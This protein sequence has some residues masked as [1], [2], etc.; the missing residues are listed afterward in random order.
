MPLDAFDRPEITI[1]N[2]QK[3]YAERHSIPVHWIKD[4]ERLQL[5]AFLEYQVALHIFSVSDARR[6]YCREYPEAN[7]TNVPITRMNGKGELYLDEKYALGS[8]LN[9]ILPYDD[10]IMEVKNLI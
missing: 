9:M 5:A 8:V 10:S 7:R 6:R 2:Y 1:D 4:N 3:I